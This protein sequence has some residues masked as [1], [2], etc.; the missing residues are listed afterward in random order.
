VFDDEDRVAG[1]DEAVEDV[2]E[3]SDV[4]EVESGGGLVED[5]ECSA[6]G[7]FY[8]LAGELDALGFAAGEGVAGLSEL[9]IVETDVVEG[10]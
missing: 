9:E 5:V 10:L 4:V 7:S 3:V 6:G 1:I 2:E 8:E